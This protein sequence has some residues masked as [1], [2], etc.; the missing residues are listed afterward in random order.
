MLLLGTNTCL[1]T[2]RK[3]IF[4]F[5]LQFLVRSFQPQLPLPAASQGYRWLWKGPATRT[6]GPAPLTGLSKGW[7]SHCPSCCQCP[8]EPAPH[9][10]A[11]ASGTV[12]VKEPCEQR[13]G[14]RRLPFQPLSSRCTRNTTAT[15]GVSL[16]L[17]GD[18][19][20][21]AALRRA[22]AQRRLTSQLPARR[23]APPASSGAGAPPAPS[24][25]GGTAGCL[26]ARGRGQPPPVPRQAREGAA[27]HGAAPERTAAAT[28]SDSH[29]DQS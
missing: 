1:H 22:R 19:G 29:A 18:S 10:P 27:A 28:M 20:P 21:G 25:A 23:G 3:Q 11:A 17:R 6:L 4:L 26:G 14:R 12:A 16:H 15:A 5:P 13:R 2:G 9:S 24:G 8:A 7:S